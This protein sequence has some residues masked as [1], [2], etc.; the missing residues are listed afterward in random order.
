MSAA[1]E[2]VSAWRMGI[3]AEAG[4]VMTCQARRQKVY[5]PG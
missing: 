4:W 1:W 5:W 3:I 2:V